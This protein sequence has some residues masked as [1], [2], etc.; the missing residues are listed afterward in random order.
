MNQD[1]HYKL[2]DIINQ[3]ILE[4]LKDYGVGW[5]S[6]YDIIAEFEKRLAKYTGASYV[7][8]TDCC[9][10]ALELSIRWYM[11][12]YPR[13]TPHIDLPDQ[14]YLSVA[15][16]LKKLDLNFKIEDI[17]WIGEYRLGHFPIWDSARLLQKNM[18][19]VKEDETGFEDTE[20]F[21]CLSFGHGKPLTIGKGGAILT[22]SR[23]AYDWLIRARYDGRDLK[24][25]PWD[26]ED[27]KEVGYHYYMSPEQAAIGI[28]KLDNYK[29]QEPEKVSYPS[30]SKCFKI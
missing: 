22:N 8:T 4:L 23:E 26:K 14:T 3:D 28:V 10:H 6:P 12:K 7:I 30:L 13:R 9:T 24:V 21:K 1:T 5:N 16:M 11:Q 27:Y 25:S 18:F 20:L 2:Q 29:Q 19:Q 17:D 15:M